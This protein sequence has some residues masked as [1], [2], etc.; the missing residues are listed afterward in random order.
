MGA[1]SMPV[2]LGLRALLALRP[3][4]H[5]AAATEVG[6]ELAASAA[7]HVFTWVEAAETLK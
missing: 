5:V 2:P 3:R 4:A 6:G 7:G 1:L